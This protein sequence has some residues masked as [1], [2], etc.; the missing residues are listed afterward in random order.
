MELDQKIKALSAFFRRLEDYPVV[1]GKA[2]GD[3][4]NG[5]IKIVQSITQNSNFTPPQPVGFRT[6]QF[7]PPFYTPMALFWR[8]LYKFSDKVVIIHKNKREVVV[9]LGDRDSVFVELFHQQLVLFIAPLILAGMLVAASFS[10]SDDSFGSGSGLGTLS[11]IFYPNHIVFWNLFFLLIAFSAISIFLYTEQ[12]RPLLRSGVVTALQNL[13]NVSGFHFMISYNW[14]SKDLA[15]S[16]ASALAKLS[17]NVWMDIYRLENAHLLH[18]TIYHTAKQALFVVVLLNPKYL[19]SVNCCIELLAVLE[20]PPERSIVYIDPSFD[21]DVDIKE[22][23]KTLRA[24]GLNVVDSLPRLIAQI[25]SSLLTLKGDKAAFIRDWW[26]RQPA[27]P[28]VRLIPRSEEPRLV[29]GRDALYSVNGDFFLPAN[30]VSS[31]LHYITGE[32]LLCRRLFAVP[33]DFFLAL[34]CFLSTLATFLAPAVCRN[35]TGYFNLFQLVALLTMRTSRQM[36][37]R[38]DIRV[39]AAPRAALGGRRPCRVQPGARRSRAGWA[40]CPPLNGAHDARL[41]GDA[42]A[43]AAAAALSA[44]GRAIRASCCLTLEQEGP[45]Q[46]LKG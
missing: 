6:D 26:H 24:C 2:S 34:V 29:F 27:S 9:V 18:E 25:D 15:L 41:A 31:G 38:A 30:A 21:W 20:L 13:L 33:L 7:Y 28:S 1:H 39:R 45:F 16:M 10:F 14:E 43:A 19:V 8:R 40:A 37:K 12:G 22:L 35:C 5:A 42:T 32:G 44:I 11:F 36:L 4:G 3:D 17:L 46:G 23:D